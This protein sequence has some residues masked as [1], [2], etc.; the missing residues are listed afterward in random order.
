MKWY[1]Y[2]PR[3]RAFTF[4]LAPRGAGR[5]AFETFVD[6]LTGRR[7]VIPYRRDLLEGVKIIEKG[8]KS[9]E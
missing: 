4:T 5:R 9:N 6:A 8:R 3:G 7:R 2:R 1:V